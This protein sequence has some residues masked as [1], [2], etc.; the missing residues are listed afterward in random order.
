MATESVWGDKKFWKWVVI[1]FG[2]T[3]NVVNTMN[4]TLKK[5]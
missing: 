2:N 3:V 5:G 1:M 4:C